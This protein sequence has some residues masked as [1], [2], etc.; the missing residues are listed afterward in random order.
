VYHSLFAPSLDYFFTSEQVYLV[1]ALFLSVFVCFSPRPFCFVV[2]VDFC[3]ANFQLVVLRFV[4]ES[5][6][7]MDWN[8]SSLK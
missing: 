4:D 3:V 2:V 1:L 7:V 6:Q 5:V 8:Y